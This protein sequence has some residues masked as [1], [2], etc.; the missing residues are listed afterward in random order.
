[1]PKYRLVLTWRDP[2]NPIPVSVR[3]AAAVQVAQDHNV[4]G[5]GGDH[6]T[7]HITEGPHGPTWIVEGSDSDVDSMIS[8]WESHGNVTVSKHLLGP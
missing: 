3:R 5:P 7:N 6:P 8:V 2:N 1:M 4:T